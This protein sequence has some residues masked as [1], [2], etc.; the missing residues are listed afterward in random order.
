[1]LRKS[2][3]LLLVVVLPLFVASY[4]PKTVESQA[5]IGRGRFHAPS[6]ALEM[7]AYVPITISWELD[8]PADVA[9]Q[10]LDLSTDGGVTFTVA[11]AGYLSPAQRQMTWSTLPRNASSHA[12]LAITLQGVSG[13]VSRIVSDEFSIS[14]ANRGQIPSTGTSSLLDGTPAANATIPPGAISR[15]G[16]SSAA[17]ITNS[18][19]PTAQS[20]GPDFPGTGSCATWNV[21]NVTLD[22]NMGEAYVKCGSPPF[23]GEPSVAQDPIDPTHFVLLH[24]SVEPHR[25][26]EPNNGYGYSPQTKVGP[27]MQASGYALFGDCI[28][29]ITTD[30]SVYAVSMGR[31]QNSLRPDAVILFRSTDGGLNFGTTVVLPKPAGVQFIDKPVMDVH[32]TNPNILAVTVNPE[33]SNGFL[34]GNAYVVICTSATTL[35]NFTIVQPLDL[36]GFAITPYGTLHPL[37]DPISPG[38]SSYWLFLVYTNN[39]FSGGGRSF[40]GMTVFQY[41][42]TGSALGNGGYPINSLIRGLPGS[43]PLW[44]I[45]PSYPSGSAVEKCL[46]VYDPR[47]PGRGNVG[48]ANITKATIDYCDP[49]AHRMYLPNLANSNGVSSDLYLTVWQYSGV[50]QSITSIVTGEQE[51]YP[52]EM[53]KYVAC[54]VTDGHGRVWVT[55]YVVGTTDTQRARMAAI[56]VHRTSAVPGPI[57]Y[58]S[59]RLPI[60]LADAYDSINSTGLFLGDYVYTQATFYTSNGR[61]RVVYPT[62]MDLSFYCGFWEYDIGVCGWY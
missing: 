18:S 24:N 3:L 12:R 39:D 45:N 40:A 5:S 8:N 4:E 60:N 21:P 20:G 56:A 41:L 55:A 32:K 9:Y 61:S 36:N 47:F 14:S 62:F 29:E 13:D 52:S 35:S 25:S 6:R 44:S 26:F 53:Q 17:D 1:M 2:F 27:F 42:V 11:I 59:A 7:D 15:T 31:S 50:S 48:P 23:N 57:A 30:G 37:I 33:D 49:N 34:T 43:P 10:D 28:T 46:R 22:Y 58:R 19:P 54:A 16:V 38:S 51:I